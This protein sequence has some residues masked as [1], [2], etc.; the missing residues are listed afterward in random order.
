MEKLSKSEKLE[1]GYLHVQ[2]IIEIVGKP[3]EFIVEQLNKHLE[4]IKDNKKLEVEEIDIEEPA[5]VED[6]PGLFSTF[7]DVI[8]WAEDSKD[9]IAFCFDY[10]PSSIEIIDPEQK[11]MKMADLTDLLNDLQGRLHHVDMLAKNLHQENKAFN[12]SLT[13]MLRN[14]IMISLAHKPLPLDKLSQLTGVKKETIEPFL[15]KMIEDKKLIKKDGIYGI[16]AEKPKDD[17]PE[18][19][20]EEKTEEEIKK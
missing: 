14:T 19:K 2:S 17:E 3:K 6:Q 12:A 13:N 11:I 15:K 18:K 20:S 4:Q 16:P 10:M 5:E 7:A 8:F 1:K 9:L